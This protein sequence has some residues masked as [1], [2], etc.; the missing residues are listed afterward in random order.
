MLAAFAGWQRA[1]VLSGSLPVQ[2]VLRAPTRPGR[3][4]L[5]RVDCRPW[6]RSCGRPVIRPRARPAGPDRSE[7][8][9]ARGV[10]RIDEA[11]SWR[12]GAR[13]SYPCSGWARTAV[14]WTT[15]PPRGCG[16]PCS[17]QATCST[18]RRS[19]RRLDPVAGVRGAGRSRGSG[20][21]LGYARVSV[22]SQASH[23]GQLRR[24]CDP[25]HPARRPPRCARPRATR[26]RG[27]ARR[28]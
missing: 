24:S 6:F 22:A 7:A 1:A 11:C 27:R 12:R 18:S 10:R 13:P 4:G 26:V 5:S 9:C 15:K 28:A 20:R 3:K 8:E 2:R 21:L 25:L 19:A 14:H 16:D 23:P 17:A